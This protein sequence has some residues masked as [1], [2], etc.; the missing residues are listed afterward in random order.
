M[1]EAVTGHERT[2][3]HGMKF[4]VAIPR[5]TSDHIRD[6]VR[7]LGISRKQLLFNYLE[8]KPAQIMILL[9][10]PK[11]TTRDKFEL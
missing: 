8:G 11:T 3:S 2:T 1:L 4:G 6:T 9:I 5:G 7:D 10:T